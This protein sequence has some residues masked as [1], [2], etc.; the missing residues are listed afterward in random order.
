MQ[1]L[2][3]LNNLI[4]KVCLAYHTSNPL[5]AYSFSICTISHIIYMYVINYSP[6]FLFLVIRVLPSGPFQSISTQFCWRTPR[7]RQRTN[8]SLSGFQALLW[9]G[10]YWFSQYHFKDSQ[11]LC[12]W[13]HTL[14]ALPSLQA[15]ERNSWSKFSNSSNRRISLTQFY[16]E[17]IWIYVIQ[18][19]ELLVYL[20]IL[21]M[22]GRPV[23]AARNPSSLGT[24]VRTVTWIGNLKTNQSADLT[25]CSWGLAKTIV[26]LSPGSFIWLASCPWPVDFTQVITGESSVI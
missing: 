13:R 21:E 26:V 16:L 18:R 6:N 8:H 17:V 25:G 3:L 22:L 11:N 12:W 5:E 4:L 2:V 15:R 24:W 1:L 20:W 7:S 9:A 23:A 19:W 10:I 14:R